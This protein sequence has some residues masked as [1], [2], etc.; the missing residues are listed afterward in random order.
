MAVE[1]GKQE[2]PGNLAG[3][4]EEE[5]GVSHE[6]GVKSGVY[7]EAEFSERLLNSNCSVSDIVFM[8]RTVAISS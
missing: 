3:Q 8:F 6:R 4:G 1:K 5:N 7:L 2:K